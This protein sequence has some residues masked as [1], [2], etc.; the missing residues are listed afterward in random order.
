M[1]SAETAVHGDGAHDAAEDGIAPMVLVVG[2]EALRRAAR[3]VVEDLGGAT[4]EREDGGDLAGALADPAVNLAVVDLRVTA[5]EVLAEVER[6]RPDLKVVAV[7]APG[8]TET[9]VAAMKLGADE[10]MEGPVS[11]EDLKAVVRE[12]LSL[13]SDTGDREYVDRVRAAR[14]QI[15][16]RAFRVARAQLA[17]AL[18][19]DAARPEAF[20][21]MGV[22]AHVRGDRLAAQRWWRMALDADGTYE[23]AR[24]NLERSTRRPSPHGRPSLG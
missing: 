2:E 7:T 16:A 15:F 21:L 12:Q 4:L 23:P 19:L 8:A 17:R 3:E 5:P 11:A 1:T 18:A 9:A 22:L 14:R 10:A 24:D 20:N 6:E 13:A